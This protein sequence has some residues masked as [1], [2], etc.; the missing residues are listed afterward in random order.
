M[1]LQDHNQQREWLDQMHADS[2]R[3]GRLADTIFLLI[4]LGVL[5]GLILCAVLGWLE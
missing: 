4:S 3:K 5:W 1:T 2:K